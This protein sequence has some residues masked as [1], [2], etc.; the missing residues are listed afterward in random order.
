MIHGICNVLICNVSCPYIYLNYIESEFNYLTGMPTELKDMSLENGEAVFCQSGPV[1]AMK[2]R[3]HT[4]NVYMLSSKHGPTMETTG[5][6]RGET[7]EVKPK[8]VIDYNQ[9]KAGVDV[10]DQLS[11]YHPFERRTIKWY[12]KLFFRYVSN[13]VMI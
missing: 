8:M 12:K 9:N 13:S 7:E 2:W 6:Q 1:T 4:R 3:D 5:R 10:S 11:S